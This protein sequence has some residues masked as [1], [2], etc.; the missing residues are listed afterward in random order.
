MTKAS[1]HFAVVEL[2]LDSQFAVIEFR[3]VRAL[4]LVENDVQK[5]ALFLSVLEHGLPFLKFLNIEMQ[6]VVRWVAFRIDF[7]Q[8]RPNILS[9]T[10]HVHGQEVNAVDMLL[11]KKVECPNDSATFAFT[12]IRITLTPIDDMIG[13]AVVPNGP[14]ETGITEKVLGF[15][16]TTPQP[17]RP[18][19]K[20]QIVLADVLQPAPLEIPRRLRVNHLH[21]ERPG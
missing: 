3:L 4:C 9:V 6:V 21:V 16:G 2:S 15:I 11:R 17:V 1:N 14:N 20:L 7:A 13:I 5:D 19:L 12:P 18:I 10:T 8:P